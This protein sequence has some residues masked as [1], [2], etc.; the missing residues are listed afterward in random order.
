[1]RL[2]VRVCSIFAS[3]AIVATSFAGSASGA[4]LFEGSRSSHMSSV[5]I[6]SGFSSNETFCAASPL[7]GT[8]SYEVSSGHASLAV[9]VKGL[10]RRTLVGIDWANNTVR[11][12]QVGTLRSDSRGRSIANTAKLFRSGETRGYKLVLTWPDNTRVVGTLWPCGPPAITFPAI[13]TNPTVSVSPIAG[14]TDGSAVT[15]TA[16]GFGVTQ[17]LFASECASVEDANDLGCGQQLAAQPFFFT[18]SNRS[19]ST[20]L[21]VLTTAATSPYDVASHSQCAPQC[22]I[23]V[24][25]G[26]GLAWAVVPINFGQ[27]TPTSAAGSAP[28]CTNAQIAVSDISGGAGLGHVDQLLVFTNISH[29]A[30]TLTGYP[31]VAG[32][33]SIGQ[34]EVQA[35]RTLGGYMGGLLPGD[36]ALPVVSLAPGESASA[37]VESTDNPIG[38][39]SCLH[40]QALLV[41]PPNLT[42]QTRVGIAD[43]GMQ[44]FPDC[45]GLQVHPVVAGS[46]GSSPG[47]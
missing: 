39:Q 46:G 44:G 6:Q 43:A 37:I 19:G 9:A 5:P 14:L 15:V 11:G 45:S 12:Y 28:P 38:S 32:L 34:D 4:M 30:C 18:R 27:A 22:V 1:M 35:A 36:I 21:V 40:F 31:G 7:K 2:L 17:K 25:Q 20:S 16:S 3:L 41:T 26:D 13:A 33:S 29:T 24:T 10:P 23:V 8:I 47:F 42:D